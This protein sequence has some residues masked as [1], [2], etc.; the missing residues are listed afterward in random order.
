M[1]LTRNRM[2]SVLYEPVFQTKNIIGFYFWGA[3]FSFFL[4][5]F[6]IIM[7]I[8]ILVSN[9]A[10]LLMNKLYK[11]VKLK[12][13]IKEKSI[14]L[15]FDLALILF[16]GFILIY[17]ILFGGYIIVTDFNWRSL[18]LLLVGIWI[19]I[20]VF[21][22]I[23]AI[24]VLIPNLG[25][26]NTV[27]YIETTKEDWRNLLKK[28]KLN[29]NYK[30]FFSTIDDLE[31]VLNTDLAKYNAT[32][33]IR[34][35]NTHS[36]VEVYNNGYSYAINIYPFSD[37]LKEREESI[38][39]FCETHDINFDPPYTEKNNLVVEILNSNILLFEKFL[40]FTFLLEKDT[41]LEFYSYENYQKELEKRLKMYY[42]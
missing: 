24:S 8:Q 25:Q 23:L 19:I 5:G 11:E 15:K 38:F 16:G 10:W 6:R 27:D 2:L 39:E 9:V 28:W 30:N 7:L 17:Y 32:M 33:V 34:V 31:D 21:F 42:S 40:S 37:S 36:R 3:I 12:K 20:E 1:I 29:D 35:A 26:F 41:Q 4:D 13:P 22:K 18:I 14:T